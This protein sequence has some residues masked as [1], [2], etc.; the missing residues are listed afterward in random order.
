MSEIVGNGITVEVYIKV[1]E[2]S[3]KEVEEILDKLER[4]SS[5]YEKLAR[6][7]V[8]VNES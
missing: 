4:A 1:N 7:D 5:L 8:K 3:E 6:V 2:E